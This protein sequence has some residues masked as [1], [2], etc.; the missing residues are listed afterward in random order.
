MSMKQTIMEKLFAEKPLTNEEILHIGSRLDDNDSPKPEES[1]KTRKKVKLLPYD[2]T[3]KDSLIKACSLTDSDFEN[4]NKLIRSEVIDKKNELDCNSKQIEVYEKIALAKPQNLRL[5]M[6]QFVKT[7]MALQKRESGGGII[8]LGGGGDFRD[9]LDFL[10][11]QG[12][13]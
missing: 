7:K 13:G 2:H 12:G 10:K 4:I 6:Y 9:F 11:G 3:I 5:L 8:K 1:K